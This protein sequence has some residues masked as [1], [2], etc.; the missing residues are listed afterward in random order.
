M[1]V[2]ESLNWLRCNPLGRLSSPP[3]DI[4]GKADRVTADPARGVVIATVNEDADPR[5]RSTGSQTPK[6]VQLPSRQ[7]VMPATDPHKRRCR[8]SLVR[9]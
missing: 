5:F 4:A 6:S 8:M 2:G 7:S 3:W 9:R 1:V